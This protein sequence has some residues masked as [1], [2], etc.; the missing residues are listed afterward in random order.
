MVLLIWMWQLLLRRGATTTKAFLPPLAI[1]NTKVTWL[2][3]RIRE[4]HCS[5]HTPPIHGC[6]IIYMNYS[7]IHLPF[8]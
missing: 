2:P 7:R 8:G 6:Y 3:F 4:S 5:P 1:R